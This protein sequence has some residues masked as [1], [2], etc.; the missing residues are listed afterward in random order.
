MSIPI[1]GQIT[2]ATV[3]RWAERPV[4]GGRRW[5]V[6]HDGHWGFR[7]MIA[8]QYAEAVLAGRVLDADLFA[9]RI[10]VRVR[11]GPCTVRP[12]RLALPVTVVGRERV[13]KSAVLL[14]RLF[15]HQYHRQLSVVVVAG[16]LVTTV[17]I[18]RSGVTAET[19]FGRRRQNADQQQTRRHRL[20]HQY[21]QYNAC[22]RRNNQ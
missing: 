1:F 15:V 2:A 19:R 14:E 10:G 11:T 18:R 21:A 13:L 20:L 17:I 16:R 8:L 12:D 5:L 4:T 6:R 3:G 9:V 7:H 22:T